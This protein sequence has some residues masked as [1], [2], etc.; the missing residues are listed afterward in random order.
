MSA[1]R[2]CGAVPAGAAPTTTQQVGLYAMSGS[3]SI[4]VETYTEALTLSAQPNYI[5][6]GTPVKFTARRANSDS[7][8]VMWGRGWTKDGGVSAAGPSC[9]LENPCTSP[10]YGSGTMWVDA[11]INGHTYR[12]TTHVTV[13]SSFALDADRT[14]VDVGDSVTFTPKY[15][16][17]PGTAARWLWVPDDTAGDKSKCADNTAGKEFLV[18]E[19]CGHLRPRPVAI[20]TLK[21]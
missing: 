6:A 11:G 20:L 9:G 2:V 5:H 12:A 1:M 15:D 10:V 4:R 13:F 16:G 8:V 7:N 21:S 18:P 14:T 3:Q 17:V 19:K